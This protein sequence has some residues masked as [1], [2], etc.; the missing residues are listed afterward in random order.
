MKRAC[1]LLKGAIQGDSR[2][3]KTIRLLQEHMQLDLF[4]LDGSAGDQDLFESSV[5]LFPLVQPSPA[6]AK[7]LR[8]T[9][10]HREMQFMERE[11]LRRGGRY[12]FVYAYD[13]TTLLPALRLG[14]RFAAKVYYDARDIYVETLN[15]HLP[16]EAEGAKGAIARLLLLFMKYVGCRAEKRMIREVD[17]TVTVN[18]SLADYFMQHYGI[19]NVVVVLNCPVW[20][21][22]ALTQRID[23]RTHFGWEPE[24]VVGLYQGVLNPGR[25]LETLLRALRRV[26][27][28]IKLV[29]LGSGPLR[30]HLEHVV[31]ALGL[32]DRVGFHQKVPY[33]HLLGYTVAADF[34]VN[35]LEGNL[36]KELALPNKG[37]EYIHAGIVQ[38]SSDLVE[39]R[40]VFSEHEVGMLT[41]NTEESLAQSLSAL[42][43]S[44]RWEEYRE[45]A[46]AA[47]RVYNWSTQAESLL[48]RLRS[49]RLLE[50][51]S[52]STSFAQA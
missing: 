19:S 46:R 29:L 36:S 4:Y 2:P 52:N 35:L 41:G 7:V 45:N 12:D 50:E 37:F 32:R 16:V 9:L 18:Q 34:G 23:F 33:D 24:S 42:L 49:D 27:P 6:R 22:E 39:A 31:D 43:E 28:R 5:R 15:Q 1:V 44:D 30:Q 17:V 11:V 10:F 38:I 26:D 3:I 21:P 48:R 47:R 40:R 14:R 8:H 25:A 20:Q 13:L 51:P